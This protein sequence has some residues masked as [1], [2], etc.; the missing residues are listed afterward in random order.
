MLVSLGVQMGPAG[1]R[2]RLWTGLYLAGVD[3][4]AQN[5]IKELEQKI[6]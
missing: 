1:N 2:H 6:L 3:A 5:N 4:N